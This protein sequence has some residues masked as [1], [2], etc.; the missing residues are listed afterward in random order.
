MKMHKPVSEPA[1]TSTL[2]VSVPGDRFEQEADHVADAVVRGESS[3]FAGAPQ[4]G[5]DIATGQRWTRRRGRRHRSR[6][7][8]ASQQRSAAR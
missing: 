3:T 7:S 6:R 8:G 5:V 4:P 1:R 2:P